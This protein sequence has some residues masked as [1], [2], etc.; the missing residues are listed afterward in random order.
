[1]RTREYRYNPINALDIEIYF[2]FMSVCV[3]FTVHFHNNFG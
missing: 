2:F 1:M 3:L